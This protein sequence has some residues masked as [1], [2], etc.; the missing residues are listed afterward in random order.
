MALP[1]QHLNEKFEGEFEFK[2]KTFRVPYTL[3]G[4]LVQ[5]QLRYRGPKHERF[6]VL[7]IEPAESYPPEVAQSPTPTVS[8]PNSVS[9]KISIYRYRITNELKRML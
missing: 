8:A 4:D 9:N 7:H 3:P 1:I 5:F 2:R 6:K